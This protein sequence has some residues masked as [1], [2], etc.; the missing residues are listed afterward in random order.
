MRKVSARIRITDTFR[1]LTAN[2]TWQPV[3]VDFPALFAHVS[4]LAQGEQA[5]EEYEQA[6]QAE[7]DGGTFTDG[8]CTNSHGTTFS[9]KN[10]TAP[11]T[12]TCS[13]IGRSVLSLER[14]RQVI[15]LL[16]AF[17]D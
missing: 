6:N 11:Q 10:E 9:M 2:D 3:L 16:A 15:A 4:H 7:A 5:K 8:D 12:V 14:W 17:T 13:V 1:S